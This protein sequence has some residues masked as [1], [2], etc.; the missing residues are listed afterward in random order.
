[1][2]D[3]ERDILPYR[4]IRISAGVGAG[5]NSW[6]NEIAD[7]KK[8]NGANFN[9]LLITSRAATANAQAA[10]MGADRWIDLEKI[11][12]NN[13]GSGVHNKVVVTNSGLERF[14]KKLSNSGSTTDDP[15]FWNRFD[16]IIMDEAHSLTTDAVFADS[17]FYVYQF[18][19]QAVRR[20]NKDCRVILM[21]GTPEPIDW[22][23]TDELKSHHLYK[24]L[25]LLGVC[26]HLEPEEVILEPVSFVLQDIHR[27]LREGKCLIYFAQTIERI[28]ELLDTLLKGGV[29]EDC[30]GIAYADSDQDQN[31]SKK[32]VARKEEIR[33]SLLNEETLP[34]NIKVFLTTSQNKEGVNINNENIRIMFSE[35][36]QRAELVQMAGRLRNGLDTLLVV[37]DAEKRNRYAMREFEAVRDEECLSAVCAAADRYQRQPHIVTGGR[38]SEEQIQQNI[39]K[40]F[41]NIRY[42]PFSQSFLLYQGR[43]E[44]NRQKARDTRE[45]AEIL[46]WWNQEIPVI[47]LRDIF[48]DDSETIYE[49]GED[50]FRRWFPYSDVFW[51]YPFEDGEELSAAKTAIRRFLEEKGLWETEFG[52]EEREALKTAFVQAL[53]QFDYKRLGIKSLDFS[54]LGTQLKKFGFVLKPKNHH[55]NTFIITELK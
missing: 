5:K 27:C 30:I 38:L 51:N 45:V 17:P 40:V 8:S 36:C 55:K 25:D 42:D 15:C 52:V 33:K 1:M 10:K 24:E 54:N 47:P 21:T 43:I 12:R 41:S 48:D 22:L 50:R 28:R 39:E 37:Y 4:L 29:D 49:T 32:M 19:R 13:F 46:R 11:A 7:K 16:F 34:E 18:L 6:V 3:V 9:T 23:F 31:F 20:G 44:G 53:T 14:I 2:I 35:S 26:R